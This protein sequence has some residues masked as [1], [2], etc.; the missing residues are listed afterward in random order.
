MKIY[1]QA[2]GD[3]ITPNGKRREVFGM[4]VVMRRKEIVTAYPVKGKIDYIQLF[5]YGAA[6]TR[7]FRLFHLF[8][9]H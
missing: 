3:K 6:I 1:D 9:H 2:I 8:P 7:L 4:K 5:V